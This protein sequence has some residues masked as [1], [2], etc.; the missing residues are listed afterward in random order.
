MNARVFFISLW[1]W[2]LLPSGVKAETYD[3]ALAEKPFLE[4][5]RQNSDSAK[6]NALLNAY[7][8]YMADRISPESFAIQHLESALKLSEKSGYIPGILRSTFRLASDLDYST[9]L[10]SKSIEYYIRCRKVAEASGNIMFQAKAIMGIG[11]IHYKQQRWEQALLKFR[12]SLAI[13]R[14]VNSAFRIAVNQYL[15]GLCYYKTGKFSESLAYLD[16]ATRA[17]QGIKFRQG[18]IECTIFQGFSN[19]KL[20][21]YTLSDSLFQR[22]LHAYRTE[23]REPFWLLMATTGL[24]ELRLLQGKNDEALTYA[25]SIRDSVLNLPRGMEIINDYFL[26]LSKCYR[27][28]HDYKSALHYFEFYHQKR[29]SFTDLDISSRVLELQSEFDFD[30]RNAHLMAEQKVRETALEAEIREQKNKRLFYLILAAVLMISI[31]LIIRSYRQVSR[32]RELSDELLLNILPRETATELK[33]FGKA[34]PKKHEHVAIMFCDI[35][36]FTVISEKLAPEVLVEWLDTYFREFDLI[37]SRFGMEKIKTIGD[38]YMCVSGLHG[39]N[40]NPSESAVSAALEI[41]QVASKLS[42]QMTG[43]QPF[44]F[45]IGIHTG[46]VV[47]GVVGL[48]KYAYDIWG[49]SVNIAARMEQN[50]QPGRVNITGSTYFEVK[51]QF[52]CEFRGLINAKNKGNIEMYFVNRRI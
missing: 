5:Y 17:Y 28:N 4:A 21:H 50:S 9:N 14:S 2:I 10:I 37:I 33:T 45:R 39:Q 6:A 25:L 44:E 49:D 27:A 47:S 35:R 23:V 12:E 48:H 43:S 13:G 29:D 26:V 30:K 11:L 38:A 22:V 7:E 36:D 18:I 1:L 41:L 24:A 19:M 40:A 32:Q 51:D 8:S 20:G 42:P 52:E 31:L 3:N 15:I 16:S 34:I 46:P